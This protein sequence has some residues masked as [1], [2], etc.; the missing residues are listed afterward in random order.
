[1]SIEAIKHAA[2]RWLG[3]KPSDRAQAGPELIAICDRAIRELVT[4][5]QS[6]GYPVEPMLVPCADLDAVIAELEEAGPPLPP[7][8][9]EVWRWIGEISL[10][11]LDGYRHMSFWEDRVGGDARV[12]ACDGVVV[13][14]PHDDDGWTD[15]VID[16]LHEQAEIGVAQAFPISPDSLHK[17]NTSGGDSYELVPNADDAWMA[18]LRAFSWDGPLRPQSA[19]GAS[20]PDLVS[21]LRTAILECGGFPGLY[22]SAGFEPIRRELVQGLPVF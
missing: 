7:A 20:T 1:M 17:D 9:A 2:D 12:F 5:L 19:P 16:L 18:S 10:V 21:Y 11:D 15:Y 14:A 8:L 6:L 13:Y 22:G 4:R 3:Q